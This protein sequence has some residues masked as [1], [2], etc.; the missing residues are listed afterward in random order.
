M[1]ILKAVSGAHGVAT[2]T[3]SG[4]LAPGAAARR[5]RRRAAAARSPAAARASALASGRSLRPPEQRQ[6]RLQKETDEEEGTTQATLLLLHAVPLAAGAMAA[7]LAVLTA[8]LLGRA[9]FGG[10]ATTTMTQRPRPGHR[11]AG[12]EPEPPIRSPSG[13]PAPAIVWF[14]AD[15]RMR[16]HAP[17]RAALASRR[18]ASVLPVFL[19]DPREYPSLRQAGSSSTST[20]TGTVPTA[21]PRRACLVRGAVRELRARLRALG[22]DLVVRA[23]APEDVLPRL[24]AAAGAARVYC[25][26]EGGAHDAAVERAVASALRSRVGGCELR[27]GSGGKGGEGWGAGG[28][29]LHPADLPASLR[30]PP[31]PTAAAEAAAAEAASQ[32]APTTAFGDFCERVASVRVREPLAAPLRFKVL[33]PPLPAVAAASAA[34]AAAAAAGPPTLGD[35]GSAAAP[36]TTLEAGPIPSMRELGFAD[37]AF[38]G[39]S[40]GGETEALRQLRAFAEELRRPHRRR[41]GAASSPSSLSSSAAADTVAAA[42]A[43]AARISPWLAVGCLSPRDVFAELSAEQDPGCKAIGAPVT[44]PPP[45]ARAQRQQ[46]Q[47]QQQQQRR[48]PGARADE[49][50]WLAS[51]LLLRDFFGMLMRHSAWRSHPALVTAAAVAA[52]QVAFA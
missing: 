6:H 49:R 43:F 23:G 48:P 36:A 18:V 51:E 21:G 14:R 29:L 45:P 24:A 44:S 12:Q 27:C 52:P 26:R 38:S 7:R 9:L 10:V 16:D 30:P 31:A 1:T 37:D 25:H 20:S 19:F 22:S 35:S 39:S 5:R 34:I 42:S 50:A 32:P 41:E 33:P 15:L 28:A 8:R 17:L 40:V 11:P 13:A 46:Q 3:P 47:Q 2:T 4:A